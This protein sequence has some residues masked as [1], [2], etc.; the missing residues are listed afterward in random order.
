MTRKFYESLQT[1]IQTDRRQSTGDQKSKALFSFQLFLAY[2]IE[3]S[4]PKYNT[5]I[6]QY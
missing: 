6:S 5:N 2:K 4:I 1:D 3:H